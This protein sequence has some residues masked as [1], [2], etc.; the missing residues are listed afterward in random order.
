MAT[1]QKWQV[2]HFEKKVK[3]QFNPLID[4][5]ELLIKQYKTEATNKAVEKLAKKMGADKIINDFRRAEKMLASARA[6]AITF[7]DKKKPKDK[8]LDYNFRRDRDR[9]SL[10]DCEGQLREWASNLV[11]KEIEK[12]PEGAKL[13]ILKELKTKALDTVKECGSPESLALALNKVSNKIGLSWEQDL[14]ALPSVN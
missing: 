12:R 6:N 10:E 5:Q 11:D 9:L 14:K 8:E 4:D 7:F 13:R 2:E 1:M 3:R